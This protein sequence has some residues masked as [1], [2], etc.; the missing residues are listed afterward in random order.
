MPLF[1]IVLRC[2]T[3]PLK[4]VVHRFAR[5]HSGYHSGR[6]RHLPIHQSTT[7]TP[8]AVGLVCRYVLIAFG[9]GSSALVPGDAIRPAIPSPL[10]RVCGAGDDGCPPR[11][12]SGMF[13]GFGDPG[14][15]GFQGATRDG[16]FGDASQFPLGPPEAFTHLPA[17]PP[18][19]GKP[20]PPPIDP[21][22][23]PRQNVP[24]PGAVAILLTGILAIGLSQRRTAMATRTLQSARRRSRR[25][26][27]PAAK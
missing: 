12:A 9:I 14:R 2:V 13:I 18:D 19:P 24:E 17:N 11:G 15:F 26:H 27:L 22:T 25:L 1:Q 8:P 10:T 4:A 23:F 3:R 7:Y 6:H 16:H 20:S 21:G 5:H